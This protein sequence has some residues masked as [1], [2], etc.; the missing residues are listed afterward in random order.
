MNAMTAELLLL[1]LS[2]FLFLRPSGS[3]VAII[4][5]ASL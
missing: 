1:P 5:V 2:S 4:G 3:L